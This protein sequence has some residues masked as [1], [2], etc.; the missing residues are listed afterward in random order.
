[1]RLT[2]TQ[3]RAITHIFS[4]YFLP[5][6]KIWLFGSRVDNS[7]KGGDIDLYIET[8]YDNWSIVA[9]K[10]IDFLVALKKEIGD[11]RI[12]LVIH[13]LS[14]QQKRPIYDEAKQTGIQLII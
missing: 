5:Q 4:Q 12:D 6:D 11:Q 8:H 2:Q 9:Q 7:K 13:P 14:S 1:M 10:Q 3:L